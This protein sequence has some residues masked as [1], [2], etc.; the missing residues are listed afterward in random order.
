MKTLYEASSAVEGHMILDLLRQE[1]L[2]AHIHGEHLQGAIGE[3][4]AAGLVR[5]V[6]DEADYAKAREVVERWDSDQPQEVRPRSARS[7]GG[8]RFDARLM[9]GSADGLAPFAL[10]AHPGPLAEVVVIA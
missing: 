4:P 8:R 3:F 6:V 2:T 1:G 5:L 7:L 10:S 9:V